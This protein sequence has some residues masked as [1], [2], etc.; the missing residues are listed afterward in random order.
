MNSI[1][2]IQMIV[3]F[4][5]EFECEIRISKILL[6]EINTTNI[7]MKI[8]KF[9]AYPSTALLTITF[10]YGGEINGNCEYR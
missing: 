4:E 5:E 6:L 9:L 2:Y 10:K 1:A 8:F 7:T 3:S